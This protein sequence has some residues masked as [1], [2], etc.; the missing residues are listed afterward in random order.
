MQEVE[1]MPESEAA[2]TTTGED[3]LDEAG[4]GLGAA[5]RDTL[6]LF[7]PNSQALFQ[8]NQDSDFFKM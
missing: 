7:H 6:T 1:A 2:A 4:G 3:S 5:G 8:E